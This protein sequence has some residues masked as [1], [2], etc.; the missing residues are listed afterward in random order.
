MLRAQLLM[1]RSPA[2]AEQAISMHGFARI[3]LIGRIRGTL[4]NTSPCGEL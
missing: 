3:G 2:G 1:L 4:R